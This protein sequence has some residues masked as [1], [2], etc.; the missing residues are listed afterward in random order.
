M[1]VDL[2]S[3]GFIHIPASIHLF[4]II[5]SRYLS[6]FPRFNEAAFR[7][8]NV[9]KQV[10]D[11]KRLYELPSV[12]A[13][14]L[15]YVTVLRILPT[16]MIFVYFCDHNFPLKTAW[17]YFVSLALFL[18]P[19]Y[20]CFSF[21]ELHIFVTKLVEDLHQKY[22]LGSVFKVFNK[23]GSV[24]RFF[25]NEYSSLMLCFITFLIQVC[26]LFI[27]ERELTPDKVIWLLASGAIVFSRMHIL[28]KR[29]LIDGV[30]NIEKNYYALKKKGHSYIPISSSP[31][32][33][34]FQ[35]A[36][37]DLIGRLRSYEEG[38]MSWIIRES[39]EGRFRVIGEISATIGHSLKG[40]VHAIYF[41]L[42]EIED[43]DTNDHNWS[44]HLKYIRKNVQRIEELSASLNVSLRN[45]EDHKFTYIP[46]AHEEVVGL[47]KA[48]IC[49]SGRYS[50]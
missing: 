38:I 23:K 18:A 46:L 44:K 7:K 27:V 24:K 45:P 29:F 47:F 16:A 48:R 42:D 1:L 8:K 31:V 35:N 5:F 19:L 26:L 11:L 39:E 28:Y 2:I 3:Y 43:K 10:E 49:P 6:I 25:I 9:Q 17:L 13:L 4:P 20:A 12:R 14:F 37:N 32:L 41:S 21:I 36:F 34:R 33:A 15:I 30:L 22:D 40:P 50:L